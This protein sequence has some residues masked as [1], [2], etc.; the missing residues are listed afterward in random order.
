[1]AGNTI[2]HKGDPIRK[3]ADAGAAIN[4]GEF[5]LFS[6]GALIPVDTPTAGDIDSPIY[7]AKENDIIG[8]GIDDAYGT[9]DVVH[10][11]VPRRGG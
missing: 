9:G 3:E 1:M 6:S 11:L 2:L 4:P 8:D 10:Y 7:I 5:I